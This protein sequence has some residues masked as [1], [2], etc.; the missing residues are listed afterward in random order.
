MLYIYYIYNI[1]KYIHIYCVVHVYVNHVQSNN[2]N[3]RTMY[4]ICLKLRIKTGTTSMSINDVIVSINCELISQI[5]LVFSFAD[6]EQV[7][8]GWKEGYKANP[9]S[10][11]LLSSC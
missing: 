11:E 2:T 5:V 10:I 9:I 8:I 4:K 7:N 3:T 6:L 1:H